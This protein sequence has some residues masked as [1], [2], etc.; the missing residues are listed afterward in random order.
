M[1]LVIGSQP[2]HDLVFACLWALLASLMCWQLQTKAWT[3]VVTVS[4]EQDHGSEQEDFFVYDI[5]VPLGDM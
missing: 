1:I 5:D 2:L 4:S 3:Y